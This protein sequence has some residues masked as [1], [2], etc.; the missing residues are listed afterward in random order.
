MG[1]GG[2]E[3]R[4]CM[5]RAL[6]HAGVLL[7]GMCAAALPRAVG[8]TLLTALGPMWGVVRGAGHARAWF[9]RCRS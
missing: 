9:F 5:R 1:G 4:C 3:V 7:Q 6:L 8:G 2:G